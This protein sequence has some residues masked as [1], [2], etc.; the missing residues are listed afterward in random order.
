MRNIIIIIWFSFAFENSGTADELLLTADDS[1]VSNSELQ[2]TLFLPPGSSTGVTSPEILGLAD[3]DNSDLLNVEDDLDRLLS[4]GT[5]S[6][7]ALSPK[8]S[9]APSKP[10]IKPRIKPRASLNPKS[11]SKTSMQESTLGAL[12][13]RESEQMAEDDIMKYIQENCEGGDAKL[14]LF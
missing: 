7:P 1:A 9:P 2:E 6:K 13:Q 4:V 3:E 12:D 8:A 14:D 11:A 5:K 10:P